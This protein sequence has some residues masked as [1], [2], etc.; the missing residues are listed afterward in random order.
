ME[1]IP[2]NKSVGSIEDDDLLISSGE[3]TAPSLPENPIVSFAAGILTGGAKRGSSV[4]SK[5]RK[6]VKAATGAH[7]KRVNLRGGKRLTEA[8]KKTAREQLNKMP[9][10]VS[11]DSQQVKNDKDRKDDDDFINSLRGALDKEAKAALEG[12]SALN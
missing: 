1:V 11:I 2:E 9:S 3:V 8:E 12:L 6:P 4:S 7:R 5:K 10:D